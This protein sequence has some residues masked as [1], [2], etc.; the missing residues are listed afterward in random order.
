MKKRI[1]LFLISCILFSLILFV[2]A[3]YYE[4]RP[5]KYPDIPYESQKGNYKLNTFI[6]DTYN[7][8]SYGEPFGNW[9]PTR[10]GLMTKSK[11]SD[12]RGEYQYLGYNYLEI[13]ITNDRYFS[14]EDKI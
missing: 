5:E 12:E 2:N 4:H 3:G 14:H 9:L 8:V 7:I 10:E 1:T 13:P 11:N 6:L